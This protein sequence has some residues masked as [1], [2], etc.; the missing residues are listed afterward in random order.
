MSNSEAELDERLARAIIQVIDAI[1]AVAKNANAERR[2]RLMSIS[3]LL[4]EVIEAG[5]YEKPKLAN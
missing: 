2:A 4:S 1:Y 5:A 3:L